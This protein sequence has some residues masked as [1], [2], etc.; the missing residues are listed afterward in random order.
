MLIHLIKHSWLAH[1]RIIVLALLISCSLEYGTDVI[2]GVVS[3][4]GSGESTSSVGGI[5]GGNACA[6][7]IIKAS[8]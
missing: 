3:A 7:E 5:V 8:N 6:V 4:T 1:L 2:S